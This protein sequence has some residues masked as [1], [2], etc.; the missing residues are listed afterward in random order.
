MRGVLAEHAVQIDTTVHR[1]A[2]P[3][4]P[5]SVV[6]IGPDA[7]DRQRV[8]SLEAVQPEPAAVEVRQRVAIEQTGLE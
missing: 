7:L 1:V 2:E 8:L 3:A 6:R 5:G 4:D